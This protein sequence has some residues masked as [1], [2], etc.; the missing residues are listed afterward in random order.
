M[1]TTLVAGNNIN[2]LFCN[3]INGNRNVYLIQS[4][5]G[6]STSKAPQKLGK[7]S[8]KLNGCPMDGGGMV[9]NKN[10]EINTVWRRQE[11]IIKA[12]PGKPENQIGTGKGCTIETINDKN[13]YV[14]TEKTEV[15]ILYPDGKKTILS[16]GHSP[17]LKAPD[18]KKVLRIRE[19]NKQ[20]H[21][22]V[23]EM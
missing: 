23:I 16:K 13:I 4:V 14:W 18:D 2:V 8:W 17:I 3:W 5:D 1:A 20:I 21:G 19:T 7:E 11:K 10:G 22:S 12:M 9:I 15:I 6:G